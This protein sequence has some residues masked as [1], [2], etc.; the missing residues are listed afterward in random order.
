MV[1]GV[2]VYPQQAPNRFLYSQSLTTCVS[3]Q[4]SKTS[5]SLKV[6]KCGSRTRWWTRSLRQDVYAR[7]HKLF[8][9]MPCIIF[10]KHIR[11]NYGVWTSPTLLGYM[12]SKTWGHNACCAQVHGWT[13]RTSLS[14]GCGEHRIYLISYSWHWLSSMWG[15]IQEHQ[16]DA[17]PQA[18]LVNCRRM[19][20]SPTFS[21]HCAQAEASCYPKSQVVV[22]PRS[23]MCHAM[24]FYPTSDCWLYSGYPLDTLWILFGFLSLL[25]P[26]WT[27]A[28]KL[29][30]WEQFL[31]TAFDPLNA[32]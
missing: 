3:R 21:F 25:R 7:I 22:S 29:W 6:C 15:N 23:L 32:R 4:S 5:C 20:D 24:M 26:F 2:R 9:R 12:L 10:V 18:Y 28:A 17:N 27:L 16:S 31:L 1:Q 30:A 11:L 13:P 8:H 14:S 19:H